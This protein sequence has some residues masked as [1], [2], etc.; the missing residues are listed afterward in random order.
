MFEHFYDSTALTTV[1]NRVPNV[2]GLVGALGIFD[3]EPIGSTKVE[4]RE[5]EN[6]V[7]VLESSERGGKGQKA[8]RPRGRTK[9]FDTAHFEFEDAITPR[10]V[11]DRLMVVGQDKVP[12]SIEYATAKV[13]RKLAKSHYQTLEWLRVGALKGK[14]LDGDGS[15]VLLDLHDFFGKERKDVYFDLTNANADLIAKLEEVSDHIGQNLNGE[16]MTGVGGLCDTDFFN[17][18]SQHPKLEKYYLQHQAALQLLNPE[19]NYQGNNWGRIWDIN[20]IVKLIEYKGKAPLKGGS[21][22]FIGT[23]EVH[24][25]PVGTEDTF[26]TAF[27][28]ADTLDQ[29]NAAPGLESDEDFGD[30]FQL[31]ASAEVRPHGKGVD[32]YTES[33]PTPYVKRPE[34]LVFGSK[35]ATAPE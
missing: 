25:F 13:L 8:D 35:L 12:E 9:T 17:R 18:I 34:L 15:T 3:D 19:R 14:L 23:G 30:F 11:Q 16:V 28:P 4:V 10:D 31:F 6:G 33:N 24:F 29:V 21:Q 20:G 1:V 26:K 27:A 32:I 7:I 5:D 2:Y 22:S